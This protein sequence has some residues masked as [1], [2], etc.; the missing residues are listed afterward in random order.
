MSF[1]FFK[2]NSQTTSLG[3]GNNR[4]QGHH[5][6]NFA[7][8][9][10]YRFD[11]FFGNDSAKLFPIPFRHFIVGG[12]ISDQ[13]G[14]VLFF[15]N[16]YTLGI[17]D[18]LVAFNGD[19]LG[20]SPNE[21]QIDSNTYF[22]GNSFLNSMLILPQPGDSSR[23]QMI[24]T[25][26]FYGN[27]D[28]LCY[29]CALKLFNSEVVIDSTGTVAITQ[30]NQVVFID[31]LA[32]GGMAATKHGNGRD[33]WI[34]VLPAYESYYHLLLLSP[35]GITHTT[36]PLPVP[37]CREFNTRFS[38]DG[39][40]LALLG[41]QG[42]PHAHSL[43]QFDRCTGLLSNPQLAFNFDQNY[44]PWGCCFSPDSRYLYTSNIFS[45]FR[46]D[47]QASNFS[48]SRETIFTTNSTFFDT[49]ANL[50]TLLFTMFPSYDG[51]IYLN[52]TSTVNVYSWIES[53]NAPAG[54][55]EFHYMEGFFRKLNNGTT[56]VHPNY[57]LGPKAGSACDTLGLTVG[58]N[59]NMPL[60]VNIFPNPGNGKLYLQYEPPRNK[61]G[62]LCIYD[63]VGKLQLK[64][65]LAQWTNQKELDLTP[66]ADG[67]YAFHFEI[68]GRTQTLKYFKK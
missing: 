3:V 61:S 9:G 65:E 57:H 54:Q 32:L 5:E 28:P 45:V 2:A 44:A 8:A 68:E 48:A 16:G 10:G 15:T 39:E 34:V 6:G 55:V 31:T 53:P 51:R 19:S 18:S 36:H 64:T 38:P 42:S 43:L 25:N 23:Y 59:I 17:P 12:N 56:T 66:L 58:I 13:N 1:W 30:K 47:T 62:W 40:W 7:R 20:C 26:P 29:P 52:S 14:H 46:Y 41:V 4:V 35:S 63:A 49:V 27:T 60:T 50:P 22:G 37:P 33:W 11:S 67:M 24:H 21:A